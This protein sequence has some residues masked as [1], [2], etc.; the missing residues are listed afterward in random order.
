MIFVVLFIETV[1]FTTGISPDDGCTQAL[2]TLLTENKM[3]LRSTEELEDRTFTFTFEDL[4]FFP[5]RTAI[6]TCQLSPYREG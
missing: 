6:M 4:R 5:Q 2:H 3:I 1:G